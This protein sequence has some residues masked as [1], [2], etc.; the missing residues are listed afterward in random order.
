MVAA[1]M[2]HVRHDDP[3]VVKLSSKIFDDLFCG[4]AGATWTMHDKVKV[5]SGQPMNCLHEPMH[6]IFS[7][8]DERRWSIRIR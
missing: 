6:V 7:H 4:I 1:D 8:A 3:D 2:A 5:G